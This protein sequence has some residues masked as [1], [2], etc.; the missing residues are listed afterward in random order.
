L[1]QLSGVDP[2]IVTSPTTNVPAYV[3]ASECR[4]S[5]VY[6]GKWYGLFSVED[7]F[8]TQTFRIKD[9]SNEKVYALETNT[10]LY[11]SWDVSRAIVLLKGETYGGDHENVRYVS[12]RV[13]IWRYLDDK[14]EEYAI[15]RNAVDESLREMLRSK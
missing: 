6:D 1:I 7:R 15:D 11:C 5:R 13:V 12:D 10:T 9:F 3:T 8:G 2:D 14:T 4:A